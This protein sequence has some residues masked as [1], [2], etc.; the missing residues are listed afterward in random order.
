LKDK[1]HSNVHSREFS[2]KIDYTELP[3]SVSFL[4]FLIEE[5][6]YAVGGVD[7][8]LKKY[9]FDKINTIPKILTY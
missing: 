9:F 5:V 3:C 4:S 2:K 7:V 6:F 1:Q 8:G